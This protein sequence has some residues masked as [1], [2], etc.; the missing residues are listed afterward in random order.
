ML[1]VCDTVK[2]FDLKVA[3]AQRLSNDLWRPSLF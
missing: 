2:K 1:E 3:P